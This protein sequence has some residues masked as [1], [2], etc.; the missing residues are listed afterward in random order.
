M[1]QKIDMVS[2]MSYD[3]RFEH[4]DGVKAWQY[5]RDLFPSTTIVN[6]GLETAPEGWAGG[7]LVVEDADAQ[8]TGSKILGNQ[9]FEDLTNATLANSAYSV[10]RYASAVKVTR[11]NSNP[12]DGAM[13][14]QILKTAT[15][16][17]GSATVASPSTIAAKISTLY[18][19]PADPR[20]AWK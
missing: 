10:N 18:G 4:Y 7:M 5:Y 6:I 1:A 14:W 13:L 20:A 9:A 8:C 2:I 17:C 15:A 19:L 16:T 3:A 11:P 12:R